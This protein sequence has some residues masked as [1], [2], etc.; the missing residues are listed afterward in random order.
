M[1]S[2]QIHKSD[3][4]NLCY[5]INQIGSG[6]AKGIEFLDKNFE[7][8]RKRLVADQ[9]FESLHKALWDSIQTQNIPNIEEIKKA[10]I[11]IFLQ[12]DDES[13]SYLDWIIKSYLYVTL[14]D[15]IKMYYGK[16][17]FE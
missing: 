13:G 10:I 8:L 16:I 1:N 7:Q 14:T 4:I 5:I 11:D 9:S 3:Y 2:Y 17:V 15:G 6:R 12:V